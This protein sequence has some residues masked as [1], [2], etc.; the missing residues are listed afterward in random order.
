MSDD[1]PTAFQDLRK[2]LGLLFR[3]ART[4]VDKLPKGGVEEVVKTSAREVGRAIE[5]VA[6]TLEREVFGRKPTSPPDEHAKGPGPDRREGPPDE[7]K[8]PTA[9]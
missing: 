1:K 3:A 7:P 5:N 2:G 6:S 9:A 8:P 4:A